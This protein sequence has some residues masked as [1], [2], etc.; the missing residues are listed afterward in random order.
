VS[1]SQPVAGIPSQ[2]AKPAAQANPHAP[3]AQYVVA[4]ATVGHA[5]PQ[6]PQC[7]GSLASVAQ[8]PE[9]LACAAW[10]LTPHTPPEHIVP[11][12]Q[13][14]PHA[15]QLALSLRVSTSQPLATL[16]SQ[17]AYPV[18]HAVMVHA[19]AV[20][21]DVALGSAQ[22]RPQAPQLVALVWVLVSQ[23][24]A[25]APSQLPKPAEHPMTVHA[26][27]AQPLVATLVSAHTAPQ[28]LQL[29]GSIAVLAQKA[30]EPMPQVRSGRA[31]VVPQTPAEHT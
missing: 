13:A 27:A 25:A 11:A 29:A 17:L 28:A 7:R 30:V 16:P 12:A 26:P 24:L 19:P 22:V 3:A 4:L 10:Q 21:P 5:V 14:V 6:A 9:Q 23:P 18:A 2:S 15:P 8:V 31:Q 20:Q 1:A